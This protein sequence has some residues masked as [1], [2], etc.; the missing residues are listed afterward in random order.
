MA[1]KI[2]SI[3]LL[4]ENTGEVL[5]TVIPETEGRAVILENGKDLES[6]LADVTQQ[7]EDGTAGIDDGVVSENKVW[8]SAKVAQI[9]P[10]IVVSEAEPINPTEGLIWFKVEY[11]K[12][13][14][15]VK[16]FILRFDA[17]EL[18]LINNDKVSIWQDLSVNESTL[19]Q[20]VSGSQPIFL[21][22]GFNDKPTVQFNNSYMSNPS[23]TLDNIDRATI[24]FVGQ[25]EDTSASVAPFSFGSS[26]KNF[27]TRFSS[28]GTFG[29][30]IN[31]STMANVPI[32]TETFLF[33]GIW[34]G[35]TTRVYK[36]GVLGA[37]NVNYSG[38]LAQSNPELVVGKTLIEGTLFKGKISEIVYFSRDLNETEVAQVNLYL[39]EKWGL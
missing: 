39:L 28:S 13:E 19:T 8:S 35:T 32:S 31:N 18:D 4:D 9:M 2:I 27:A 6:Q 21:A 17:S 36:N 24:F 34:D 3:Q 1:K 38:T 11:P 16:D 12:P 33:A 37:S 26:T 22:R 25:I 15:P 20:A 14:I 23:F 30:R 5:E 7:L 29:M 10:K